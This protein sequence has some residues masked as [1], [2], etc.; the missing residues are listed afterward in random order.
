MTMSRFRFLGRFALA[1]SLAGLSLPASTPPAEATVTIGQTG[2]PT[3]TCSSG[4]DRLQPTV[5]SGQA[6]VVPPT[7][8]TGTIISWST[9]AGASA[10]Q[11]LTLKV[12]RPLGGTTYRVAGHDGPHLL[13]AGT[14]NTFPATVP[15]RAG[16]VLGSSIPA[17][18]ATGCNFVVPGDSYPFRE[19]ELADGE[20]ADFTGD[21]TG[22]QANRRLD[23]SAAVSPSNSFT[24]GPITRNEKKGTA[25]LTVKVPNPGKLTGSGTGV[26]VAGATGPLISKTV[27]APGAVKLTIRANGKKKRKLNETGKVQVNPRITYTPA[28]GDPSTQPTKVKLKKI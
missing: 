15:V 18:E 11:A 28:G 10:G 6:Y 12:F 2:T 4:N 5:T 9:E 1:A 21:F 27:S 14:L 7:V 16:D 23:I 13:S 8:V 24:L 3:T 20:S 26:K 17:A 22:V 25:T 19:A